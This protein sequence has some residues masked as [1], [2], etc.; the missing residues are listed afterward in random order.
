[1]MKKILNKIIQYLC[2]IHADRYMH[3]SVGAVIAAVV[4][5]IFAMFLYEPACIGM[6]V[7]TVLVAAMWKEL[8]YDTVADI[9]DFWVTMAGGTVVWAVLIFTT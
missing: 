2:G 6:S 1:M 9:W 5:L 7:L 8:R 3:F 4:Y